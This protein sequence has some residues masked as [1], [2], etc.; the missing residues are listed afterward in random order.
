[1]K[2][3][4]LERWTGQLLSS[5]T[6][7]CCLRQQPHY[8]KAIA[9]TRSQSMYAAIDALGLSEDVNAP[10]DEA[11]AELGPIDLPSPPPKKALSSAKLSA[12]HARLSL[13]KKLPLQT[14]SRAL[15]DRSADTSSD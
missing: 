7:P 14:L 3:V 13:P 8:R 2:R 11:R 10:S 15:I 1:M 9:S 12:L 5:Q 4:R 6:R